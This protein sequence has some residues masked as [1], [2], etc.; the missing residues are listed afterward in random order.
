ML[1]GALGAPLHAELLFAVAFMLARAQA[2]KHCSSIVE[3]RWL[4]H[5]CLCEPDVGC[6]SVFVKDTHAPQP[7][8]RVPKKKI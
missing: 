2:Q 3:N 1:W 7:L 5:A 4:Q 8:W 6:M